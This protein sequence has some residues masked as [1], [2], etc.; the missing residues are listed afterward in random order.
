LHPGCPSHWR[1]FG[2]T[3]LLGRE[4][5]TFAKR[6]AIK[7]AG[8]W[9]KWR[10][11]TKAPI[12]HPP[13]HQASAKTGKGMVANNVFSRLFVGKCSWVKTS[14]KHPVLPLKWRFLVC[15]SDFSLETLKSAQLMTSAAPSKRKKSKGM[16]AS[17]FSRLSVSNCKWVQTSSKHRILA[18]AP[19]PCPSFLLLT[20]ETLKSSAQLSSTA[21]SKNKSWRGSTGQPAL[22]RAG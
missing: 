1:G 3:S 12:Q 19:F 13:L 2:R 8:K 15:L 6:L 4:A 5:K 20:L 21:P 11:P 22:A 14:F 7:L 18:Q 16:V 9:Q 10:E 17:A